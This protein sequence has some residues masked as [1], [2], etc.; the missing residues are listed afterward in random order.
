MA[1]VLAFCSVLLPASFAEPVS[2]NQERILLLNEDGVRAE[3]VLPD[4][5][6][7]FTSISPVNA[8]AVVKGSVAGLPQSLLSEFSTV[9]ISQR[10][11]ASG[12]KKYRVEFFE[13]GQPS[14]ALGLF[15]FLDP[16]GR[17]ALRTDTRFDL[18]DQAPYQA[19][20]FDRF[21][22]RVSLLSGPAAPDRSAADEAEL[23]RSVLDR[24]KS[25][26]NKE[27]I[28]PPT[29]FKDLPS[30]GQEPFSAKLVFGPEGFKRVVDYSGA[31]SIRFD[32]GSKA[33]FARYRED[34]AVTTLALIEYQTPQLATEGFETLKQL[35]ESLQ[36]DNRPL[37]K[38]AGNYVVAAFG[39]V[40]QSSAEKLIGKV[41]YSYTVKYLAT[42]APPRF[43]AVKYRREAYQMLAGIFWLVV[44]VTAGALFL[45][46]SYGVSLFWRRY[47]RSRNSFSDAGGMLRLNL[48]RLLPPG[49]SEGQV[50]LIEKSE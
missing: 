26:V 24:V 12:S 11:Y 43:D 25:R 8:S 10:D 44:F 38:R 19:D 17:F 18:K 21:V 7:G 23:V 45:G 36:P 41:Q 42:P 22:V 33:A 39:Y 16:R 37:L 20:Y 35:G 28:S 47:W 30:E 49:P 5:L 50:R 29:V 13:T 48:D 46:G 6:R 3:E 1:C 9:R 27:P 34:G 32:A 2:G 15:T 40:N 14:R 4:K 31:A